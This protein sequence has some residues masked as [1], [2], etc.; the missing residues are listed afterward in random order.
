MTE[1]EIFEHARQFVDL[2]RRD[3]YIQEACGEDQALVER[4]VALLAAHEAAGSFLE[5]PAGIGKDAAET[6]VLP[7]ERPA[8]ADLGVEVGDVVAGKYKLLQ[9]IGEGGM[10]VVY[11]AEQRQPVVRRVALKIIKPGLHSAE[12]VARF[13]GEQQALAVM[14]HPHIAKVF[15]AGTTVAG[16]PYF[17][18]ELVHGV[19]ITRY[20]DEAQCSVAERLALFVPVCQAVQH[21]HKKG[22]IHRDI[23][24]S[25]VLVALYDG[26]PVPKVIDF[27]VAK[28]IG[29]T[30]TDKTLFT[31]FGA[32]VGTLEYMSPEQAT[33]NALDVDSRSDIYSLGVLL[34]ELLTG[35]TPMDRQLLQ[36]AAF[37]EVLRV[38]RM[39]EPP[40]PSTRLSSST[41]LPA[42]AA[43]RRVE[44]QRLTS[45]VRGDLDWVV[46]KALEKE[47]D[48]R[49]DTAKDLADDVER[50]LACQPIAARPP[51]TWYRLQK[52][53]HRNRGRLL[54]AAS[55]AAIL[56][57]AS[58]VVARF[59]SE[60]QRLHGQ[61]DAEQ[62]RTSEAN[63]RV[64]GS[65]Q[66]AKQQQILAA[67]MGQ[68][69]DANGEFNQGAALRV[70]EAAPGEAGP[71]TAQAMQQ[72]IE[73]GELLDKNQP[74]A[75]LAV[76]DK[77]L[78]M[79]DGLPKSS[80]AP[81]AGAYNVS[82]IAVAMMNVGRGQALDRLHRDDQ[83]EKAWNAALAAAPEGD[84]RDDVRSE[85]LSSLMA[86]GK[87]AKAA[88][89]ADQ[90]MTEP[91][92]SVLLLAAAAKTYALAAAD[93]TFADVAD[94]R[95]S[96]AID[97]LS[98][99]EKEGYFTVAWRR[100]ELAAAVW[101]SLRASQDFDRLL[102]RVAATPLGPPPQ[103]AAAT[104]AYNLIF[105]A[106]NAENPAET[107]ELL[108]QALV[109]LE[110]HQR[111]GDESLRL[112]LGACRKALAG[113][114]LSSQDRADDAESMFDEADEIVVQLSQSST[115]STLPTNALDALRKLVDSSRKAADAPRAK[116]SKSVAE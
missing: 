40:K 24:P 54:V 13:E 34:Y 41:R 46:M 8:V 104:S 93:P 96:Q 91:N 83:A 6:E 49:Y 103:F 85:W 110:S 99:A 32:L 80:K 61:V 12:V 100:E 115:S 2:G 113:V 7:A 94:S 73:G 71:A 56:A 20:C 65:R 75:A 57:A 114:K 15:D 26:K 53:A 39:D 25:N 58:G 44:P 14:E 78:A 106:G 28:A 105:A 42:I 116:G 92:P 67:N 10:G 31:R 11:M 27:G 3:A 68:V 101:N 33:F 23:K 38:I 48:R 86:G 87:L 55:V 84:I 90:W 72:G 79:V 30:L 52:F 98:R 45:L 62:T 81:W 1:R 95:R 4:V 36:R 102:A 35:E 21:A 76:F 108:D 9:L 69:F 74:A 17:V 22:I 112:Y 107:V 29:P 60:A 64:A 59:A 19:P 70:I 88:N 97:L 37:D 66:Q 47:R 16:L 89:L 43:E 82:K 51:S 111:D 77:G 18:M 5:S 50:H 109:V 63:R